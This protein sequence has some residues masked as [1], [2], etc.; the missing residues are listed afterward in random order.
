IVT[1]K[2]QKELSDAIH[3]VSGQLTAS[4]FGSVKECEAYQDVVEAL[5]QRCGRI[6]FNGMPT[7]V[8]VCKSMQHGGPFPSTTDS[9]FSSVGLDAV[10]RFVRP[11]AY[12]DFPESLLPEALQNKNVLNILR[13]VNNN[14]TRDSI[15]S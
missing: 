6:I 8:E 5:Q 13:C 12:Q 10:Y 9:R 11:V 4:V 14:W 1:Y 2:N 3:T 15:T 7:G